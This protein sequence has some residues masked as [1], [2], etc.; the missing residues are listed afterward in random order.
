[1][2]RI[3]LLFI[4]SVVLK[5]VSAQNEFK[6]YRELS[7]PEENRNYQI[8]QVIKDG[9]EI[10]GDGRGKLFYEL[11]DTKRENVTKKH[12]VNLIVRE[13]DKSGKILK[14]ITI[15]FNDVDIDMAVFSAYY[16]GSRRFLV[17]TIR[18]RFYIINLSNY[19]V[20]GPLSPKPKGCRQDAISGSMSGNFKVFD[21]GQYLIGSAADF[22]VFCYMLLD[23]YN[24][25]EIDGV[26]QEPSYSSPFY[27]FL[28]QRKDNIY[29]GIFVHNSTRAFEKIEYLFKGFRFKLNENKE[30]VKHDIDKQ[31]LVLKQFD[32][33]DNLIDCIIDYKN[34][35]LLDSETDRELMN[36][37]LEKINN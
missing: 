37:I 11:P 36:E 3:V 14:D 9:F 4:L 18:Y 12:P 35:K 1:M 13:S 32:K 20:I 27:F 6:V 15:D 29:N 2:K 21:K 8:G 7:I 31:Y 28:D 34:G 10:T 30:L 23:L 25:V 24:P 16:F 19:K 33:E 22:G 26:F 5:S 17:I